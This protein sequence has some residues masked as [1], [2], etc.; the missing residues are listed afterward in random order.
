M[1]LESKRLAEHRQ[2]RREN[3]DAAGIERA[4]RFLA[5]HH[6][7]RRA[8]LAASLGERKRAVREF[9]RREVLAPSQFRPRRTPVQPAGDHQVQHQPDIAF[10]A[11]RDALAD[12][13]QPA[14]HAAF[15]ALER[16]L[17]GSQQKADTTTGTATGATTGAAGTTTGTAGTAGTTTGTAGTAGT[18]TSTAGTAGTT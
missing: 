18:T 15:G 4:Q 1:I 14:H 9:E 2:I 13:A 6:V 11:H 3:I 7:Q 16:R 10:H 5:P 12:A 17:Q 8:A